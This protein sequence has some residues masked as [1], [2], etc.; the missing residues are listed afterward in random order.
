[1]WI[2]EQAPAP[3]PLGVEELLRDY[4]FKQFYFH[5][6]GI[7]PAAVQ[8]HHL[9]R[10][11][12]RAE[13]GH[14]LALT[15]GEEIGACFQVEESPWHSE[16]F[17]YRFFRIQDLLSRREDSGVTAEAVGAALD[18]ATEEGAE[19]ATVRVDSSDFHTANVLLH[20][21]FLPV[22]HTVKLSLHL[23]G[24]DL[25]A[26]E[27]FGLPDS[28]LLDEAREGDRSV[29]T[30]L[31]ERTHEHSHFFNDPRMEK[32]AKKK[33]FPQWMEKCLDGVAWK[34]LVIRQGHHLAGFAVLLMN[35]S[36]REAT[37]H[38]F[39]IIDFLAVAPGFQGQGL[40]K[41][42]VAESLRQL[43]AEATVAE[44]RT[45]ND[46]YRALALYQR[47]GFVLTGSDQVMHLWF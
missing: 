25:G 5:F 32:D 34:T 23:S 4:P 13:A 8:D 46:N 41:A 21:G 12:E 2:L 31:V 27:V 40:G 1:M 36:L 39:G 33:L 10:L 6:L 38:T 19:V 20:T 16:V 47:F 30:G 43:A 17:G 7:A 35:R 3:L 45:M 44:M 26:L 11:E 28:F 14:L 15:Q 24:Y 22:G 9:R 42:L 29:L 37:G 18:V